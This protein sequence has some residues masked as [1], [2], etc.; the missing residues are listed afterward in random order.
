MNKRFNFKV[1]T[2]ECKIDV[3]VTAN[4]LD[5]AVKVANAAFPSIDAWGECMQGNS[6]VMI[7]VGLK[8]IITKEHLVKTDVRLYR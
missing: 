4:S 1:E 7:E 5:E 8:P 6:H 3:C 2:S